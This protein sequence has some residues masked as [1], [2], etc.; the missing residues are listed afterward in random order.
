MTAR[1]MGGVSVTTR[2]LVPLDGSPLSEQTVPAVKKFAAG[3]GSC[4]IEL[5]HVVDPATVAIPVDG[6]VLPPSYLKRAEEWASDYL[7]EQAAALAEP[8]VEIRKLVSIGPPARVILDH[9]SKTAFDYVFMATHGRSGL[10]RAVVGSVTDRVIREAAIPVIAIHPKLSKTAEDAWPGDDAATPDLIR[11]LARG[12]VL[13][14]RAV[15]VLSGRGARAVPELI[16]A[17]SSPAAETRQFAART[18]G[19]IGDPAAADALAER[20]S[21][22]VWEVRWEAEEAMVRLKQAGVI[23]ALTDLTHTVPDARHSLAAL[24]VL[25]GAPLE[26]WEVL[27]PVT[28]ALRGRERELTAPIAAAKA[29]R[30]IQ[31]PHQV[32]AR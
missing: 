1:Q 8:G 10:V 21:D 19:L 32:A 4:S 13:S 18:L 11:L 9:I 24:H 2:I 30:K 26:L 3:L 6:G 22:D 27:K 20:L 17:L 5:L 7:E 16:A 14:T 12:D 28:H 23:A 29:L 31:Q 25:E 15:D